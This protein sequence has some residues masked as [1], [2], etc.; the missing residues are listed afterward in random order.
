MAKSES[1]F[2]VISSFVCPS[3]IYLAWHLRIVVQ[4]NILDTGIYFSCPGIISDFLSET[5]S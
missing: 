4:I 1:V 2:R 5:E 3:V